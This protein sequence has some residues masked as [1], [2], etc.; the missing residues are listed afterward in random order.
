MRVSPLLARFPNL[1]NVQV[2]MDFT[3]T[4]SNRAYKINIAINSV[5]VIV[6]DTLHVQS[7]GQTPYQARGGGI[8]RN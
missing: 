2:I 3:I 4:L 1:A 8:A 5:C 7:A 6:F